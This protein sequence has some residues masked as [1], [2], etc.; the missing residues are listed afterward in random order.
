MTAWSWP[1]E[2]RPVEQVFYVETLTARFAAAMSAQ[3]HVAERPGARWRAELTLRA[4]PETAS[5]LDSACGAVQ[6]HRRLPTLGS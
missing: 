2:I 4:L 3:V 1:A 5:G 6:D